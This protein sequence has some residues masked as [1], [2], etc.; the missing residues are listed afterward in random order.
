M[1]WDRFGAV[2]GAMQG[3]SMPCKP[4]LQDYAWHGEEY[5]LVR[6]EVPVLHMDEPG[7]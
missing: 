4:W 3:T 7:T 1:A 5:P 6:V 2:V